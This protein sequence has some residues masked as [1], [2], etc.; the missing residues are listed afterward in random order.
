MLSLPPSVRIFV[1]AG[2]TDMRRSFDRLAQMVE[3]HWQQ[4]PESGHLYLFFNR[5]CDCLSL[6]RLNIL[7]E[8]KQL[9]QLEATDVWWKSAGGCASST[10]R[11]RLF[12]RAALRLFA[13]RLCARS[14]DAI[15]RLCQ[16]ETALCS[17]KTGLLASTS[18]ADSGF[19]VRL[20]ARISSLPVGEL[21]LIARV[22][23]R[24][25]F[26]VTPIRPTAREPRH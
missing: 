12:V 5:R 10:D 6:G 9:A 23:G 7:V 15:H 14:P 17:A 13:R 25:Q 16:A 8:V 1:Y 18:N 26:R 21:R 19:A 24:E 11:L 4:N 22:V 2:V 20:I 3:E